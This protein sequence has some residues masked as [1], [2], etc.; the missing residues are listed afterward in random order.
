MRRFDISCAEYISANSKLVIC[1]LDS[2]LSDTFT[3]SLT[4][5]SKVFLQTGMLTVAKPVNNSFI[6]YNPK[7]HALVHKRI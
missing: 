5:K 2:P 4:P 3:K 6:V 1:R 7:F